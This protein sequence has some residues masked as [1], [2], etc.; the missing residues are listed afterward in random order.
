VGGVN[1]PLVRKWFNNQYV[2]VLGVEWGWRASY[3]INYWLHLLL[4]FFSFGGGTWKDLK[5]YVE[6]IF[7]NSNF[8]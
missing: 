3:V 1:I 5:N 6:N 2:L 7:L 8:F 4:L